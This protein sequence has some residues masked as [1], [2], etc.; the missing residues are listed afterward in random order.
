M[1]F[2][3]CIWNSKTLLFSKG[4]LKPSMLKVCICVCVWWE[5][6]SVSH[7]A[8]SDSLQPHRQE[9]AR[10]LCSW[11]SQGKNTG[12]GCHALLQGIF[13]TQGSN[14]GLLHCRQILYLLSY[15]GGPKSG[16]GRGKDFF[17]ARSQSSRFS[18]ANCMTWDYLPK[19]SVN[20]LINRWD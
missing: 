5:V 13:P 14:L 7:S 4:N 18:S 19:F 16:G 9:P 2:N 3:I 17:I 15:Q 12:V 1:A 20:F 11:G 8:V 10:L 6:G